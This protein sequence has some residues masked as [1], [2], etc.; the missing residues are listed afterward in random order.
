VRRWTLITII[1]LFVVIGVAAAYQILIASRPTGP[2]PGPG[3][4][5][6][7]PTATATTP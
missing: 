6:P 4:G 3:P 7:L 1:A 2:L 5:H